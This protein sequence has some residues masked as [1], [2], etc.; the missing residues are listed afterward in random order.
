[1]KLLLLLMIP[2]LLILYGCASG[3]KEPDNRTSSDFCYI[4]LPI[5]DHAND[6]PETRQQVLIHNSKF[7]C[8]CEGI[9]PAAGDHHPLD[10]AADGI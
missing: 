5:R 3:T 4:A 2:I 10:G 8:L 6:T 7:A 9:C 1:M